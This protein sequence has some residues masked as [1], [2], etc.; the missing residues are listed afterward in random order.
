MSEL[1][2]WAISFMNALSYVRRQQFSCTSLWLPRMYTVTLTA[3][4]SMCVL[5]MPVCDINC[6]FVWPWP[7]PCVTLT[8]PVC[9]LD[10][11]CVWPWPC[12]YVT[13]IVPVCDINRACVWPWPCPCLTLTCVVTVQGSES[14]LETQL[15]SKLCSF[16]LLEVMYSRLP[17]ADVNSKDSRI[18]QCYL[19]PDS[20]DTGKEM[21]KAIT[22]YVHNVMDLTCMCM[23]LL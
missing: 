22:M 21:N 5:S 11:A 16:E 8:V 19:H 3:M 9:D 17:K 14:A 4:L 12:L 18:N 13:L 10:R 7:C 6:A 23:I 2:E 1:L 15:T 20:A